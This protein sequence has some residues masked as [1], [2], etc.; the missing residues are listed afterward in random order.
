MGVDIIVKNITPNV[1]RLVQEAKE[2]HAS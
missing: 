2:K 1:V